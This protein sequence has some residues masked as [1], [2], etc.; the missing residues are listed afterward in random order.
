[1]TSQ[2]ASGD[3]RTP[4]LPWG[5]LDIV[6]I[7]DRA[8]S[9]TEDGLTVRYLALDDL[10]AMRRVAGRPKDLRRALELERLGSAP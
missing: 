6:G 4:R 7:I 5:D 1:V 8:V 10:I 3:C 9:T 2:H